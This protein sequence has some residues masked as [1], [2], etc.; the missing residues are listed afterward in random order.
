MGEEIR[1]TRAARFWGVGRSSRR[2]CS[3]PASPT[4]RAGSTRW[5]S[6]AEPSIETAHQSTPTP[7]NPLGA[8]GV[9]EAG[10]TGATPA[11]ANA[12]MDAL[13]PFGIRHLDMPLTPEKIW[14]AA[15][16]ETEP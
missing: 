4:R 3:Q 9:G 5:H 1:T 12:V 11:V 13:K 2:R 10:T 7:L 14:R 15:N 8:K 6:A 16:S